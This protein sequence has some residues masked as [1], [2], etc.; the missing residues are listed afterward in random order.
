MAQLGS[1]VWKTSE[2]SSFS[3]TIGSEITET[4]GTS[5][6]TLG[7]SGAA[8]SSSSSSSGSAASNLGAGTSGSSADSST[9][10]SAGVSMGAGVF[11][12]TAVGL[13]CSLTTVAGA[14][15]S[16]LTATLLA[17]W[18]LMSFCMK[19]PMAFAGAFCS[20]LG[21]SLAAA[22]ACVFS[23]AA[24]AEGVLGSS[25]VLTFF[26]SSVFSGTSAGLVLGSDFF[27]LGVAFLF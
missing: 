17:S 18:E 6:V 20:C 9:G 4:S 2:N 5:V 8:T 24:M 11:S 7:T 27:A 16:F 13:G 12:A 3:S 22:S 15:S 19:S 25:T 21:C 14:G 1:G 26:G 10:F 23:I